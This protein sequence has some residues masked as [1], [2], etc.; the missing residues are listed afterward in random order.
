MRASGRRK[1]PS[2]VARLAGRGKLTRS[3]AV[4]SAL[5]AA[6][7]GVSAA[8][9]VATNDAAVPAAS[10]AAP[11]GAPPVAL[12]P[13]PALFTLTD[14]QGNWF[15]TGT[16]LFGTKSLA[17][18]EM[19]TLNPAGVLGDVAAGD[20]A[21]IVGKGVLSGEDLARTW[22]TD[23][24]GL[25]DFVA[26]GAAGVTLG[27]MGV[28]VA[29]ML[30]LDQLRESAAALLPAGDN[31]LS[32]IDAL[33]SEFVAEASAAPA[34]K[35]MALEDSTSGSALM[36]LLGGIR[37]AGSSL[38]PVT[39]NFAVDEANTD[40]AHMA[41]S[42]IWPDGAEGFPVDQS[43]AWKGERTVQL[44]EPGLYAFACKV[45]PYMLGAVVVDDPLTPGVDFG[46]KLR[47]LS[48]GMNV[49]SYSDVIAQLVNK[50]FV[51]TG[52][53][54]WQYYSG[55][56]GNEW[57]PGFSP[58]PLLT[59]DSS[60]SPQLIP[61]L[62]QFIKDKFHLPMALDE[63]G[64]TP[65]TP[66][67]GEV[68]VDTQMEKF[69]GKTKSGA[70][71][72]INTETWEIERKISAPQINM[73]NPHN[74]W[75]DKDMKYLY[76][77]EWFSDKIDVFDRV[78]GELLRQIE[79]GPSPTHV[80]TRT[81]TDELHIALGGGGAVMELAP[82]ATRINR[83][84]PVGSPTE[85]IAHPH[86][87]WMS[88]D[89]RYTVAPNVNLYNMSIIDNKKGTFKHV[90]AGEFPI[91][92]GMNNT[93]TKAYIADF[94]GASISCVSVTKAACVDNGKK[95]DY[96]RLDLW[97]DYD[98]ISGPAGAYGGLPIQIAVSPDNAGG[99]LANTFSSN[100]TIFDPKTDEIVAW[101]PCNAGCHGVNFGAKQGG[102]YY[103]YVS[104]KFANVMSIVDVD[105][106]GDGNPA[107]AAI[108][109][110]I[111]TDATAGTAMDDTVVDYMGMG[112]QGVLPLPLAYEGWVQTMP[113][114]FTKGFTCR[115]MN[116]VKYA[117]K[118]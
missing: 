6:M 20:T 92:T 12:G 88:G 82:G 115:Q 54:N 90:D 42:I 99:V 105:P 30:N 70:A 47:V 56:G 114:S 16:D 28:D 62:D 18:A 38:L 86:A 97:Q 79:V 4:T 73:N 21:S 35:P 78:S 8:G 101:L 60:G 15:D 80:M 108:V 25:Q 94:L 13:Q 44:T 53:S 85:K 10:D 34:D 96:K 48:R 55:N 9:A 31:R 84:L 40:S 113:R 46:K 14:D 68:W 109:G 103:A 50:F 33:I 87:Q 17:V 93:S 3:V 76:Q 77:S 49:P 118:C 1:L 11:A 117:K 43:G 7:L 74:M 98:P 67:V 23:M 72:R 52:P 41:A 51:I 91:A 22:N 63:V 110:K 26:K 32:Q 75:T 27:E 66:G 89:G 111:L 57:N 29:K 106:N 116:P 61:N 37:T 100:L 36:G 5:A 102:G 64:Y 45:H 69:E 24:A 81:D 39:I 58:A 95:V 107:D 2:P 83:R 104:S 71:T 19:P 112:G 59:W 65:A